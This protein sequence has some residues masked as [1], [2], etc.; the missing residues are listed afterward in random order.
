MA[1]QAPQTDD[2]RARDHAQSALLAIVAT[3]LQQVR[4]S[5]MVPPEHAVM[6]VV[7]SR[8]HAAFISEGDPIAGRRDLEAI[9]QHGQ[10]LIGE[11][12]RKAG[13]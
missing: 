1:T 3:V 4:E 5:G 10:M 9:A 7:G 11:I 12:N 6:V 8:S 2:D 13:N